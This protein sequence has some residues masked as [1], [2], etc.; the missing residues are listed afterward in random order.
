M[1]TIAPNLTDI[2][3]F[4]RDEHHE[5]LAWLRENDPVHWHPTDDAGAG[6]WALTRYSD[7][8]AAYLDNATFQSSG[9][10][11]LGGSF[12]N[13]A[14]TAANRMLVSSDPPRH[15][16]LRQVV[17]RAFAPDIAAEVGRQVARLVAKAVDDALAAGGCDFATAI[18]TELPAGALM[19]MVGIDHKDAHHLIGLTRQMIGFR[20][21]AFVDT[22]SD[23]RLRLAMIQAEI[24]EFF[25]DLRRERRRR[26]G[27][28]LVSILVKSEVNGRPLTDEEILYN[29]M[30]VAVGGNETTSHSASAG[31]IAMTEHPD[32]WRRL[33]EDP[34][35]LL[36]LTINEILRWSSTNAY[37]QRILARDVQLGGKLLRQGDSVT[38]WSVSANR[39]DRQFT[40]PWTFR[41]DRSPNRHLSFGS[42]IHRCIGAMLAHIELTALLRCLIDRDVAFALDGE[43]RRVRSNFILGFT[44]VPLSLRS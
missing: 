29:C 37:V 26:P 32:A 35:G 5:M 8:A 43:V 16:L 38:L 2:D 39:D 31:M 24:F 17:H 34:Q 41:I 4:V 3:R 1:T 22:A 9:G 30:N 19:A 18:A 6:F 28:D 27:T 36:D 7:V 12:R 33:K 44:T 40:D 23:D 20:D 25:D 14:D 21:P 11:M 15:R 42:G 13:E 10:A